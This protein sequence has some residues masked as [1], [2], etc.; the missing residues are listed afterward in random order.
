MLKLKS[1][2]RRLSMRPTQEE[3]EE[4]NILK[5]ILFIHFTEVQLFTYFIKLNFRTNSRRRKKIKRRK[6]T[7]VIKKVKF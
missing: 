5:S 3:L 6:E 2:Y 4:R 7:Y 1:F